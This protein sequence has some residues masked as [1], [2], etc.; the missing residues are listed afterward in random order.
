MF[1]S[2]R[3]TGTFDLYQKPL[4][5][6]EREVLLLQS[7]HNKTPLDFTQDGRFLLY[8]SFEVETG[9]DLWAL[10]LNRD[11]KPF[12][13]LRTTFDERE[14]QF[15]PDGKWIA[16]SSRFEIYAQPFPDPGAK[17]LVSTNGGTQPRWRRDGTELFYIGLDGKLMAAPF[18]FAANT[19]RVE[20]ST[21]VALFSTRLAGGPLPGVDRSQYDV[22]PDGQ[23]FLINGL[24][25]QATTTPITV[26]LNWKPAV[27]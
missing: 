1:G 12:P 24:V 25:E 4:I 5:G 8:R 19:Q 15:S 13:F 7:Q 14:G 6:A 18:Q 23:R 11:G 9:F 16:Y 17:S 3:G 21:A 2:T 26:V 10:P 22:S 20:P 27:H